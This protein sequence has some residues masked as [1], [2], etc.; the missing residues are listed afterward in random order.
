MPKRIAMVVFSHY[1]ADPRVRR[2]AEALA[3]AGMLVDVFCLRAEGEQGKEEMNDVFIYR[4]PVKRTRSGKLNYLFEYACFIFLAFL[5][6]ALFHIRNRYHVI[7]AHNMPDVLVFSALI[8]RLTGAKVILDLHD[9]MP[10]IYMT[11]YAVTKSHPAIRLIRFLEKCSIRFADM[12]LTPNIAFRDLFISRGCPPSKIHIVM[13]SPQEN[14]FNFKSPN[15]P[16]TGEDGFVIMYHGYIAARN[17]LDIAL[18]AIVRLRGKIPNLKFEVYGDGDFVRQFLNRVKEMNIDSFVNYRGFKPI[19]EIVEAIKSIHVG[20]IPNRM[21]PFN[22]LNLPTRIF[23]YLSMKKPVIAPRTKGIADYFD[24]ES[25][26][27][28][29]AGD[30]DS[31]ARAILD[32]YSNPARAQLRL[33][34]GINIY[35]LHRWELEK[36][37]LIKL[38]EKM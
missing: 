25:L 14:I 9:P 1:P 7:Q 28:F 38:V 10:E 4:L 29:E 20:I 27:F 26:H 2:E 34:E 32:V 6:V 3:G 37:H 18:E 35:N 5:T 33:E 11:K 31:L 13:N 17:G 19:E 36:N 16:T 23:E 22:N 24:E 21:N 30:V 8:P 12:V 15:K